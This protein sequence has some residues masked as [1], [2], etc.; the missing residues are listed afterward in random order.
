MAAVILLQLPISI[1]RTYVSLSLYERYFISLPDR[2]K[3][4]KKCW[5]ANSS[6]FRIDF[7]SINRYS[8][9]K[10]D[11]VKNGREMTDLWLHKITMKCKRIVA[12]RWAR[13]LSF[14]FAMR[15]VCSIALRTKDPGIK[16]VDVLFSSDKI[17]KNPSSRIPLRELL[18]KI[19]QHERERSL[20]RKSPPEIDAKRNCRTKCYN[21]RLRKKEIFTRVKTG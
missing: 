11:L 14:G 10:K 19:R 7:N 3:M 21:D 6:Y 13:T 20:L 2:N 17:V 9:T 12:K 4:K 18:E 1:C 8:A 5:N 16:F 15:Y